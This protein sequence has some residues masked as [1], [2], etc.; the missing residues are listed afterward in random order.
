LTKKET[1]Q[2]WE[3]FIADD[4]HGAKAP[5]ADDIK[6]AAKDLDKFTSD[7]MVTHENK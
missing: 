3:E 6:K 1:S 2:I 4:P 5:S 7:K